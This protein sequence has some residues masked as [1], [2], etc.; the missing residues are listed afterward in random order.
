MATVI[1]MTGVGQINA[2]NKEFAVSMVMDDDNGYVEV[3]LDS[4]NPAVQA[5][6][7]ALTN[8]YDIKSLNS[9]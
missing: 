2:A 8:V 6:V 5:S 4:L 3:Q 7:T 9:M 1:A